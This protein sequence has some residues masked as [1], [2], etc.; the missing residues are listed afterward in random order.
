MKMETFMKKQI[1]VLFSVFLFA[2]SIFGQ[3]IDKSQY[4]AIDPFDY[5][6]ESES[7]KRGVVRKFVSVVQFWGQSGTNMS[8]NSLDG[9]TFFSSLKITRRFNPMEFK[10]KV[11]IYYTATKGSYTDELVL[12]DVDTGITTE[13]G[14]GLKKSSISSAGSIDRTSY[15]EIDPFDYKLEVDN[16]QKGSVRKYKSIVLFWG[17]SG[18]SMSF[19]SL[20]EGTFFSSLKIT[21]RFNSMKFK[22]KVTIYYTATK[23]SY[24]DELVL[25]DVEY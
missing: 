4:K 25:D 5:K 2:G 9:G 17:Q 12:D 11:A 18:N 6:L 3:S 14:I 8:F 10:Q 23:G 20:D 24:T 1:V 7:A 21:K 15:K 16:I 13:E 19:N 22:Q